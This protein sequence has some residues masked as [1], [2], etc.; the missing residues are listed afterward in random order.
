MAHKVESLVYAGEVP[1]HG[2]GESVKN[3]IRWETAVIE[4]G[5]AGWKVEKRPMYLASKV[6]ADG[7]PFVG[8]EVKDA[9]AI[10]RSKDNTIL[11]I[12]TNKYE[13]IQ[14]E[15]AFSFVDEIIGAGQAVFHTAGSLCNG[16]RVFCTLKFK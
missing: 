7:I 14:N 16:R 3:E 9:V 10:V 11:G 5:L 12:A 13:I 15:E 6:G 2:I 1:W 8:A 4:G